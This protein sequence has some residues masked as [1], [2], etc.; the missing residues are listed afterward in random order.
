M[1]ITRTIQKILFYL[2]S[3]IPLYLLLIIQ[4]LQI[5]DSDGKI[6]SFKDFINQFFHTST[7]VAFFW[8]GVLV[9]L[10]LSLFGVALFFLVYA[11]TDGRVGTIKDAELIR[12][13]TM[14]YIVTYIVP[15]ISMDVNSA[16]SLT[17]NLILFIIIGTFYV[18]NDQLFMNPLYNIC[19]YNVFSSEE[20]IYITKISK[21][22]LKVIAKRKLSVKK[23]NLI[24][25]IYVLS[26]YKSS[27]ISNSDDLYS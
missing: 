10:F 11:N 14:G 8:G 25:D 19:G 27:K 18:K 3:F 12:E 26:E 21:S 24:G 5:T 13:D 7:S 1:K 22:K 2:S 6:L 16:R 20:Q 23:V 4:N 9:L 17:I 15:L